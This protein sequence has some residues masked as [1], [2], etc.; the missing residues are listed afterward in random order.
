MEQDASGRMLR[1][2]GAFGAFV[3]LNVVHLLACVP[4]VTIGAA[5][6]AL[7][8]VTLRYSEDEGGGLV[9]EYLRELRGCLRSGTLLLLALLL[10]AGVLAFAG[11]FWAFQGGPFAIVVPVLAAIGTAYLF[12]AFVWGAAMVGRFDQTTG[13]TIRN[14]L[15]LPAAEPWRTTVI[16]LV[17]VTAVSLAVV[18]P[19][20]V[21]VLLSIGFSVGAYLLGFLLHGAFARH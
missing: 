12:A 13:R 7:F 14:A 18:F 21:I 19:P 10:P 15:L 17:P 2:L 4:I 11:L 16:V 3:V 5:T 1:G 8:S 20:F 6:S 9:G